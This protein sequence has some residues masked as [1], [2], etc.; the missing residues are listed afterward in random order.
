LLQSL[1]TINF[2]G[3]R[4]PF[5]TFVTILPILLGLIALTAT[6]YKHVKQVSLQEALKN[7]PYLDKRHLILNTD[8]TKLSE[9]GQVQILTTEEGIQIRTITWL[10]DGL[11]KG[12][13][14]LCQGYSEFIE[15]YDEVIQH[16]LDRQFA[17]LTFDWRGQGLSSRLINDPQKGHISSFSDFI[18]DANLVQEK[19]MQAMPSPHFVMGHSMG[20]HLA[21]RLLQEYPQRFQKAILCAPFFGWS[22]NFGAGKLPSKMVIIIASFMKLLG[23][24]QSYTYGATPPYLEKTL[25]GQTSDR[26]RFQKRVAFYKKEPYILMGGPTW[27]WILESTKSLQL[28]L[29]Q[30]RIAAIQ[31]PTLLVSG[32]KDG[33]VSPE[34]H[35]QMTA[36][37]EQITLV[38]YPEAMHEILMEMDAIQTQFWKDFDRFMDDK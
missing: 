1:V 15:K 7:D 27:S 13:I 16:L 26:V 32:A 12:T 34:A 35:H 4:K 19:L 25:G 38:D 28:I 6:I 29:K 20:G 18:K 21:F 24:G 30:E 36:R 17:V 9:G 31:T 14:L 37:C 2:G 23:Y 5:M 10:P 11:A 33:M 3:N 8:Q 22:P